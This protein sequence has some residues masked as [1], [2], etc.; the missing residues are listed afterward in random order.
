MYVDKIS[1]SNFRNIKSAFLEFDKEVNIIY[2]DNAQGKTNLLEIFYVFSHGKGF[3]SKGDSELVLFDRDSF[4]V[5]MDFYKDKFLR[6]NT[7]SD[8]KIFSNE[9][10]F[11]SEKGFKENIK[12]SYSKNLKKEIYYNY[13]KVSKLSEFLGAFK[14]VLFTPEHLNLV[15]EGPLEKRKFLDSALC[16]QSVKYFSYIVNYNKILKQRNSLL[17]NFHDNKNNRLLLDTYDGYLAKYGAFIA[18]TRFEFLKDITKNAVDFYSEIASEKETLSMKYVSFLDEEIL[19][20]K[21]LSD[22]SFSGEKIIFEKYYEKLKDSVNKD[23]EK[24]ST[25]FG[26]HKDD[27]KFYID[28]KDVKSFASQGQQRSCVLA[29]KLAECENIK[30]RFDDYPVLLLDDI[31]SELDVKRQ[32][33]IINKIKNKQ[34]IIT[35][36]DYER[37]KNFEKAAMFKV[38][39][40]IIKKVP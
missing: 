32:D 34:I 28:K 25:S 30:E 40:G 18:K 13:S 19:S 10:S 33:F 24:K 17:K 16:Q 12:V 21:D 27:I 14:C 31:M 20:C 37:F 26:V 1:I 35:L 39:S 23:I 29:L 36:C 3:R 2:G 9:K 5:E 15:K 11:S 6:G 7:I 8:E 22:E 38:D 4:S